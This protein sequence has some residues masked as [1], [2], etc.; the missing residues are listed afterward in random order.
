ME[1]KTIKVANRLHSVARQSHQRHGTLRAA[2][3]ELRYR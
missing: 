3:T 2:K 1:I